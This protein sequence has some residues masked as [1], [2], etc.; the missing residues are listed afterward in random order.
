MTTIENTVA[1]QVLNSFGGFG[2]IHPD[3]IVMQI[4]RF[5]DGKKVD[6]PRIYSRC[7]RAISRLE[8]EGKS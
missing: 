1:F 3:L 8:G 5:S 2:R 6:L 4:K 7:V